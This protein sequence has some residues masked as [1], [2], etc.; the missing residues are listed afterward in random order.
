M[1]AGAGF[2][3]L[4][5]ERGKILLA[6][7]NE[8]NPVWSNFGGTVE[9]YE[10]PIQCA[11]RELLEEAGFMEDTHYKLVST[12]PVHIGH[13][14][15][16]IYRCYIGLTNSELKPTLNYEHSEYR[17]FDF[18]DIPSNLHFGLKNIFSNEKVVKKLNSL[19]GK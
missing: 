9:K 12:R 7:R 15:H 8:A 13:Y 10:T 6:L 17:W 1:K 4:C 16:F 14:N 11:K 3:I 5:P 2:I 18:S 19:I